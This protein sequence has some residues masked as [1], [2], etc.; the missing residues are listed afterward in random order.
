MKTIAAIIGVIGAIALLTLV[1]NFI[2]ATII[3]L[4]AVKA[5]GL[6]LSFWQTY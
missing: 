3:Y 1:V 2:P 4:I 6:G 5:L